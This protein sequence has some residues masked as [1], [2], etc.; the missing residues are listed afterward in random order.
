[1]I[2]WATRRVFTGRHTLFCVSGPCVLPAVHMQD[3]VQSL[4]HVRISAMHKAAV[5]EKRPSVKWSDIGGLQDVKVSR[6]LVLQIGHHMVI[7]INLFLYCVTIDQ[8]ALEESIVWS[9]KHADV[10]GR[11]GIAPSKGVLL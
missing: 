8:D 7:I 2:F 11:M 1:M 9:Y 10:Y 3:F 4:G 5:V 6:P